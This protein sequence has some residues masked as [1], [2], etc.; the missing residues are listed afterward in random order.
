MP[1]LVPTTVDVSPKGQILIPANFRR[2]LGIKPK[3][4]VVIL[5][6]IMEKKL[7]IE[8]IDKEPVRAACGLFAAKDGQS[9]TKELI[10]ERKKDLQ[11]EG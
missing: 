7:I 9:W 5:P 1:Y 2:L 11:K 8:P 4:K 3:G 6:K 10:Q